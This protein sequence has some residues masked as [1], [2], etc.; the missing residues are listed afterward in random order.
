MKMGTSCYEPQAKEES[1]Y[2]A[3]EIKRIKK[4]NKIEMEN[5]IKIK[6]YN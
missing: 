5:Y 6:L 2:E 3:L 4:L 1:A